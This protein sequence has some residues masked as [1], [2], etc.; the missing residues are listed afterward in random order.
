MFPPR[1]QLGIFDTH[2]LVLKGLT[3][4]FDGCANIDVL[5]AFDD[6]A[7]L[8]RLLPDLQADVLMMEYFMDGSGK[9]FADLVPELLQAHPQLKI[10]V[11]SASQDPAIA[12]L[13]LRL[14]AHGYLCKSAQEGAILNALRRV[15]GG[16][17]Y[18][19][20]A[21][22]HLLPDRLFPVHNASAAATRGGKRIQSLMDSAKLSPS[23][24]VVVNK[25]VAGANV[26]EIATRLRKS[27]K[28]VSTQKAAAFRKLGVSSDSGLYRL[29]SSSAE[30]R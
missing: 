7:E 26:M 11:F 1:M 20:P 5:W 27:P 2:P 30:P 10:M 3:A 14:G 29:V 23:E 25:F 4:M 13:A 22:R 12:A 9:D 19:D 21:M 24:R 8:L 17:R 6:R 18:V 16:G 15:H 28:T